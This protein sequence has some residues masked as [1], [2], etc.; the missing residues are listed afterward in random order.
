MK[1]DVKMQK[2]QQAQGF[3]STAKNALGPDKFSVFQQSLRKYKAK[4]ITIQRVIC[5]CLPVFLSVED[6]EVR[7]EL[8]KG[9][10]SFIPTKYHAEFHQIAADMQKA[11]EVK[12]KK[13]VKRTSHV[14]E[15]P[16]SSTKPVLDRLVKERKKEQQE[17]VALASSKVPIVVGSSSPGDA[18]AAPAATASAVAA[19]TGAKP[20][21]STPS[22]PHCPICLEPFKSPF[23]A[24][25]GHICC[26]ACWQN[27][28][29]QK[30]EC[31]VCKEKVRSKQLRKVSLFVI[32]IF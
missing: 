25:C 28:L 17:A 5:D 23:S 10:E 14:R 19:T 32:Y 13:P 27:W 12:E 31:P 4:D 1:E 8:L 26:H 6:L 16:S 29:Q 30:L 7:A 9:F 21:A 22:K 20:D 11:D 15:E 18:I 3:L 24:V 2:I